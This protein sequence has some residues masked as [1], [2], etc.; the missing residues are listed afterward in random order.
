MAKRQ[1][2]IP[3]TERKEIKEI[4]DSAEHYRAVRDKRMRMTEM[5][6]AAKTDL[7][8]VMLTHEA[9]LEPGED[10]TKVYRYDDEI[11]ILK[12]GKVNVKVKAAHDDDADDDED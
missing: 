7:I 1:L 3:G 12:S 4:E 2:E 10:G 6:V 5:E 11:V 8:Q 9:D